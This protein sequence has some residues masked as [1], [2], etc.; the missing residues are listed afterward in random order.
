MSRLGIVT[1]DGCLPPT[2]WVWSDEDQ[3]SR[4]RNAG[5]VELKCADPPSGKLRESDG[6][7]L[8]ST[9]P[10][11]AVSTLS[12]ALMRVG[13]R[14]GAPGKARSSGCG[15][16]LATFKLGL[17]FVRWSAP[18]SGSPPTTFLSA[19]SPQLATSGKFHPRRWLRF[20]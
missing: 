3:S 18:R 10:P 11:V 20:N 6:R 14:W 5:E 16:C 19:H 8:G 13:L 9:I 15:T 4:P 2:P 17:T 12:R 7:A 1:F